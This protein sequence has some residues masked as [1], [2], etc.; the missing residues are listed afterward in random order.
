MGRASPSLWRNAAFLRLWIAQVVSNAGAAITTVALPLTA[1]LVLGATPAQMGLLGLAGSLPNLVF[2]LAA[3]VWVDRA[4]RQRMLVGA[5]LGRAL[6]FASIPV[7]AALGHLSFGQLWAVAF[8]AGTLAVFFQ[9]AAVAL[10]S[11]V[12]PA[13]LV[14]ANS[15]LSVSDSVISIAGPGLAGGLVQLLGAPRAIVADAASYVLSA[16]PLVVAGQL[17]AGFGS[18]PYVVNQVSL[19]QALTP[20]R[21]TGQVTGARH[22]VLFGTA[23]V[24]AALAGLLGG[25][26]RIRPTLALAA[27]VFDIELLALTVSPVRRD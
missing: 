11:L 3:G 14:E 10:P 16:L 22:F 15:T 27:A 19:R 21:L 23:S 13:Q 12:A 25:T 9:I 4:R 5:D 7:A 24:G 20:V 2:G 8:L 17:L 18:P 1:V 26:I 6:L